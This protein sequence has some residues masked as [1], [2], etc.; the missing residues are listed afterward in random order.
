MRSRSAF[1]A[2]AAEVT[3]SA[4]AAIERPVISMT[5]GVSRSIVIETR[6]SRARFAAFWL[7]GPHR[8]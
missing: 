1:V 4:R 6:S 8:K 2:S 3:R 7:S 5:W